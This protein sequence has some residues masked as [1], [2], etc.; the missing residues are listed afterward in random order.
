MHNFVGDKTPGDQEQFIRYIESRYPGPYGVSLFF[1]DPDLKTITALYKTRGW[2][3]FC[4]GPRS[5]GEFLNNTQQTIAKY[6][7][8][9]SNDFSTAIF[10]A[11]Y[12]AKS[13]QIMR[14]YLTKDSIYKFHSGEEDFNKLSNCLFEGVE[15]ASAKIIGSRELGAEFIRTPTE[16]RK[17]LGWD[18][19]WRSKAASLISLLVD[20]KYGSKY[21]RGM[22][23]LY[24]DRPYCGGIAN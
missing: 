18:S 24:H 14:D 3:V 17:L 10:Y 7:Y 6:Q 12:M 15:P 22:A 20:L 16:L 21:R 1:G 4:A 8:V 2:S 11:A 9:I 5:N 19:E 13:V 23:D